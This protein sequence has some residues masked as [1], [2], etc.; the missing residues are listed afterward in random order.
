MNQTTIKR[1]FGRYG[2]VPAVLA[3]LLGM[4]LFSPLKAQPGLFPSA[5]PGLPGVTDAALAWA[6]YDNDG[7]PDLL[8]SGRDSN[9]DPF[10]ELMR[11]DASSFVADNTQSLQALLSPAAAWADYDND[12]DMDLVLTGD[13]GGNQPFTQLY[14]NSSGVLSP[15]ATNLPAF[16]AG[17]ANWADFDLDGDPD[18]LLTGFN[19]QNGYMGLIARNDGGTFNVLYQDS[20]FAPGWSP[21]VAVGD[22]DG[23]TLPD[24]IISGVADDTRS[25]TRILHNEGGFNFTEFGEL[26]PGFE[27]GS[28]HMADLDGDGDAD[29]LACGETSPKVTGIFSYQYGQFQNRNAGLPG[30]AYGAAA[31]GD[32]DADGDLDVAVAGRGTTGDFTCVFNNNNGTFTL[33]NAPSPMPRLYF[34]NI[35]W[36][37]WNQ[38]GFLDYV[39]A[40][41]D[42]DDTPFT[43]IVA[44][45]PSQQIFEP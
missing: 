30:L 33:V 42:K 23:D 14:Q 22:Y 12:G 16:M 2:F 6:D 32:Y 45:I 5:A 35:A 43:Y 3:I 25:W 40:G 17:S 28:N 36:A 26:N 1:P 29:L 31:W 44:Y 7:D 24:I 37:D 8:L 4:A 15:V 21:A 34:A 18:L 13:K 11:N 38:D 20:L 41:Q 9:G 27:Y 39:V 10:T 19:D